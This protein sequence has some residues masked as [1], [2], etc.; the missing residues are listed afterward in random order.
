MRR[1]GAHADSG[2][3][4]SSNFTWDWIYAGVYED[5]SHPR[6]ICSPRS[7]TPTAR[8]PQ[9]GACRCTA[10]SKRSSASSTFPSSRGTRRIARDDVRQRL[11]LPL[12]A[13]LA[14]GSFGGYGLRASILATSTARAGWHVVLTGRDSPGPLPR[15]RHSSCDENAVYDAGMRYEDL[16]AAVDVVVTKPGY[17]IISECIANDTAMLYTSRGHFAEYDVMVAEMPR[18]LRCEYIDL[19]SLLA[20]RWRES[21]DRLIRDSRHRL[22]AADTSGAEV[23]AEMIAGTMRSTPERRQYH[24]VRTSVDSNR[25][26]P[27]LRSSMITRRSFLSVSAALAAWPA[28]LVLQGGVRQ[29]AGRGRRCRR[30]SHDSRR[31]AARR[32]RSPRTSGARG[33]SA[34]G[35]D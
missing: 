11:G 6:R 34:P 19:A 8:Q 29:S 2:P 30:R 15:G 22:S 23:V 12:D 20:G 24:C 5:R 35:A 9:H 25:S 13:P 7:S 28:W 14:L 26:F 18:F 10:A 17:G 1:R 16:V 3:L 27:A 33:S 4:S 32:G 31:C 21:L